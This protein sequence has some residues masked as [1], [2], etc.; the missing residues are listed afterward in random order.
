MLKN[1]NITKCKAKC[2][3]KY[4]LSPLLLLKNVRFGYR[5]KCVKIMPLSPY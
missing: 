3:L 5:K 1:V 2:T 4:T